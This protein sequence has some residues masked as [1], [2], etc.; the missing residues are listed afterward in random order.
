MFEGLHSNDTPDEDDHIEAVIDM[1]TPSDRVPVK[2]GGVD[3][4]LSPENTTI[5]MFAGDDEWSQFNRAVIDVGDGSAAAVKLDD[6]MLTFM[7]RSGFP[8]ELPVRP[9]ASD[10]EFLYHHKAATGS[11]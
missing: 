10:E 3:F 2:F 9:D 1:S 5:R 6:D 11:D 7:A 8:V 4:A